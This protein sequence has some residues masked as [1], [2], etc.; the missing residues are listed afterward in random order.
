MSKQ[1]AKLTDAQR[2]QIVRARLSDY[3]PQIRTAKDYGFAAFVAKISAE[4][5]ERANDPERARRLVIAAKI[6]MRAYTK[7][8][9]GECHAVRDY[10]D[11]A[12]VRYVLPEDVQTREQAERYTAEYIAIPEWHSA[13]DCTGRA[14]T[15]WTKCARLG[16]RW[17]VYHSWALDV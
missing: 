6:A 14:F 10:G 9:A 7:A 1:I 13:Y 3:M 16:G 15:R 2:A 5:V 11:G 12:I 17:S 4:D 8:D